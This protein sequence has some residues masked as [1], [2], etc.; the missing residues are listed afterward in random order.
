MAIIGFVLLVAEL[1]DPVARVY[2]W[3][4]VGT[5]VIVASVMLVRCARRIADSVDRLERSITAFVV[6]ALQT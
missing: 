5:S 6:K 3:L 4:A 1:I 2:Y